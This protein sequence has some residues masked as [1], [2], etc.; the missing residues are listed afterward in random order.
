M[1][2]GEITNKINNIE[3]YEPNQKRNYIGASLIGDECWRKIWY[4][5]N[6]DFQ[7]EHTPRK[8]RIFEM[9]HIIETYVKSLLI[10]AEYQLVLP[11][12]HPT[13]L[14]YIDSDMSYFK[15]HF[16]GILVDLEEN[17]YLLE[18]KSA[19]DAQFN[20]FFKNGVKKWSPRYYGQLISSMGLGS[21]KGAFIIVF[22]KDNA[23]IADEFLL[24]DD[25]KFQELRIK[26]KSIYESPTEPPRINNSPIWYQCK[27]CK[28][29]KVCHG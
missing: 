25:N 2:S 16:D 12:L 21:L 23:D 3:L 5:L 26:A 19:N 4:E 9:G 10:R 14:E 20:I 13:N 1:K 17:A 29:N 7:E 8:K 28:F 6:L 11:S 24:P 22:N 27:A 18:I 15:G